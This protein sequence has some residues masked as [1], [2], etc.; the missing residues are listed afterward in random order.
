MGQTIE[1]NFDTTT[2]FAFARTP[3]AAD[4]HT[5]RQVPHYYW[6]YDFMVLRILALP[7]LATVFVL[8]SHWRVQSDEVM[9]GY[10]PVLIARRADDVL[11]SSNGAEGGCSG[12]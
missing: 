8:S 7:L 6:S 11:A 10:N 5:L 9:L 2:L 1:A 12:G 3:Q 4:V